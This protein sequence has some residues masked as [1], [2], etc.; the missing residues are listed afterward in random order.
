M[1]SKTWG[2]VFFTLGIIFMHVFM[3]FNFWLNVSGIV[4]V[5]TWYGIIPANTLLGGLIWGLSPPIGA[6]LMIIG[7]MIHGRKEE[8]VVK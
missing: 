1:R 2:L 4:P 3:T 7:G 6:V 5:N 8:E